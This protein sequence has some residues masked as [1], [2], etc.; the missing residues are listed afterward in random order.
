MAETLFETGMATRRS[1]L[2]DAHV[3]AA[4]ARK[5]AFDEDFQTFI[6]QGAWGS[7]WSRPGLSKRER[8]M[9]TLALLA[10]LGHEEEFAMH[11]RATANTG[12]SAEDIKE[13]LLH[14][15]VYAGV[16]AANGAFRIAKQELARREEAGQ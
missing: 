12:A 2:G 15:A 3:D 13:L 5:T 9:L 14:V 1:V 8:S 6:T 10:A 7:V 11:V 4:T 16:P